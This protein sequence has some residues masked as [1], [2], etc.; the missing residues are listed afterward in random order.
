MTDILAE[1]VRDMSFD[2]FEDL[3]ADIE[4][5]DG[6]TF[7]DEFNRNIF[8][9]QQ[10][11][12]DENYRL[13]IPSTQSGIV[14]VLEPAI[15]TKEIVPEVKVKFLTPTEFQNQTIVNSIKIKKHYRC[16][17][18]NK[19]FVEK[20]LYFQHI[21]I[22]HY[23][24]KKYTCKKCG[25]RYVTVEELRTHKKNHGRNAKKFLCNDCPQGFDHLCDLRRHTRK[26]FKTRPF[27][28]PNCPMGFLK[29][30]HLKTHQKVHQR[31]R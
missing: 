8:H 5:F 22:N 1:A 15:E 13:T 14:T 20:Y 3:L 31:K 30:D 18:C 17:S 10:F 21:H 25:K 19:D 12:L 9:E 4:N 16:N 2:D 24:E 11:V 28:C 27:L 29:L 23:S 6:E 26:H 7:N